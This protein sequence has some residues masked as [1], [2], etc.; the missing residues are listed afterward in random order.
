MARQS[1]DRE[2]GAGA[3][4][5]QCRVEV[6]R[7]CDAGCAGIQHV[8]AAHARPRASAS[9]NEGEERVHAVAGRLRSTRG[10]ARFS[11]TPQET[12]RLAPELGE[13]T[14][15]VLSE[16][17]YDAERIAALRHEEVIA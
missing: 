4:R 7:A 6:Q 2:L 1:G 8:V 14:D 15:E 9:D 13:N 17:G 10:A 5:G 11:A 3:E 12:T 16:L